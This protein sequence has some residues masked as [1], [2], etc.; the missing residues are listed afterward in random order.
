MVFKEHHNGLGVINMENYKDNYFYQTDE[1]KKYI[2][3][4]AV[5]L[6]KVF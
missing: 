6:I 2:N 4:K 5:W 3:I 1:I